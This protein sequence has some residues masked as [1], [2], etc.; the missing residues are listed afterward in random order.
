MTRSCCCQDNCRSSNCS[1]RRAGKWSVASRIHKT[2]SVDEFLAGRSLAGSSLA[3]ADESLAGRFLAGADESLAGSSR[4]GAECI[5]NGCDKD[6]KRQAGSRSECRGKTLL[7]LIQIVCIN[8]VFHL[9]QYVKYKSSFEYVF[10][11]SVPVFFVLLSPSS[12]EK[13]CSHCP[14]RCRTGPNEYDCDVPFANDSK[15]VPEF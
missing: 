14:K 11:F 2:C 6:I 10:F 12:L 1:E 15:V 4:A 9:V 7:T 5:N 13:C 8:S 3:G